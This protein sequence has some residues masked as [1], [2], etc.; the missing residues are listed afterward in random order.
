MIS[1]QNIELSV[2]SWHLCGIAS[3]MCVAGMLGGCGW[4]CWAAA[5]VLLG[6]EA[7]VGQFTT[8]CLVVG[9]HNPSGQKLHW[10]VWLT[11]AQQ[12]PTWSWRQI[13]SLC[14]YIL[15]STY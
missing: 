10:L 6:D 15:T 7:T 1:W 9:P 11:A 14:M 13:P 5:V 3:S 2:E 8:V 12:Q 4:C